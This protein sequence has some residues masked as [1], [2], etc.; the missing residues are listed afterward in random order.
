MKC[1][2]LIRKNPILEG[3]TWSQVNVFIDNINSKKTK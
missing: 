2:E 3:R 1:E